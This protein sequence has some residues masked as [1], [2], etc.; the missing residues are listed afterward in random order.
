MNPNELMKKKIDDLEKFVK[1]PVILHFDRQWKK[2]IKQHGLD[3]SRPKENFVRSMIKPVMF[4]INCQLNNS[5]QFEITLDT[6]FI[7][8]MANI[9]SITEAIFY[10]HWFHTKRLSDNER[11]VTAKCNKYQQRLVYEVAMTIIT[12][13]NDKKLKAVTSELSPEI[14]SCREI[15][16]LIFEL[17]IKSV[18]SGTHPHEGIFEIF[19]NTILTAKSV[20]KLLSDGQGREAFILWRNLHEQ[21]SILL[22]MVCHLNAV[23]AFMEHSKFV[24]LEFSHSRERIKEESG[25]KLAIEMLKE[26][27]CLEEELTKRMKNHSITQRS[28]YINYGWL[29]EIDGFIKWLEEL[30]EEKKSKLSFTGLQQF[31]GFPNYETKRESYKYACKFIHPTFHTM[32][33]DKKGTYQPCIY[34]LIP[35]IQNISKMFYNYFVKNNLFYDENLKLSMEQLMIRLEEDLRILIAND[36]LE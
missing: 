12:R 33:L 2:L 34:S 7:L 4:E 23:K 36:K 31:A 10:Y 21:E 5:G 14:V 27:D 17:M 19:Q 9:E 29:L 1:N 13:I 8:D 24:K 6:N 35:S 18:N 30:K 3:A 25:G 22:V 15:C 16:D 28:A 20:L 11:A 26:I 32:R